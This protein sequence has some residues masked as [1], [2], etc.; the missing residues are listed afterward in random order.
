MRAL[1]RPASVGVVAVLLGAGVW[2]W[3]GGMDDLARWAATAQRDVQNGIARALRGL[4]AG[5]PAALTALLSVCFAYGFFHAVGPG[6][7]KLV[8]GGYG[9]AENVPLGRLSRIALAGSLMQAVSAIA[10]VAFGVWALG[11]TRT[12]MTHAGDFWLAPASLAAIALVGLWLVIRGLRRLARKPAA[13][14]HTHSGDDKACSTCGHAHGPDPAQV[15]KANSW[16]ASLA[17][18]AAIGIRPCTGALFLLILGWGM[19]LHWAAIA[20]TLAMALGTASVTL[21][22]AGSAVLFRE[23]LARS[24]GDGQ[25]AAR[26]ASV[27][28]ISAGALVAIIATGLLLRLL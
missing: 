17:L 22:V 26:L 11:L 1:I 2:L 20:G 16:G 19:G 4:R 3:L 24:I 12:Q 15:A 25:A 13:H 7:G 10:L 9:V 21:A 8:V 28:E 14:G 5:D 27:I 18:I 6:H 23:S